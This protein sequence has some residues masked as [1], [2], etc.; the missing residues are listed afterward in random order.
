[1]PLSNDTVQRRIY[2]IADDI[3]QQVV[4]EIRGEPL[5]KFAIQ[6]DESTD[7]ASCAQLLVFAPYIKDG[8]FKE[9]FLFCHCL[10]S[11]TRG[12][13]VFN[14]VSEYFRKRGLSWDNVSACTTDGAPAML[15]NRSGFR[16]RVKAVNPNTKH[17]H[18][19]I[20]R[21]ALAAKTLPPELKA[22]LEDVIHMV[23]C[24]KSSALNTRL[25]RLLCQEF[26]DD[27]EALLFHAE[28]RWLSRGNML[29][30]V[31]SLRNEMVEFFERNNFRG[32]SRD[33][34]NK[35]LDKEWVIRL[36]YLDDIFTR[37][38]LLIKSLQGRFT[39]VVDF[40]D[41]IRAFI[42]KL[43][44]WEGK[45]R[46]GNLDIFENL[47]AAVGSEKL[48]AENIR[49][50]KAHLSC[51]R[52]EFQSYFPDLSEMNV[53]LIRNP[54]IVEVRSLPDEVQEE[55]VEFV[56]DSTAKDALRPYH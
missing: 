6:L 23:N 20:H 17:I 38:N 31:N 47:T 56:N 35:L 54:F 29:S 14:E 52:E 19:M 8:V 12:E 18:C 5:N 10:E 48:D 55:F 34:S 26:D 49:L 42:M 39:T 15:G 27:Q 43:D 21:Y 9:E 2:D 40:I 16:A 50:V 4:A 32:K 30:R 33:F 1:M 46:D 45:A 13:D 11:T 22:T 44:L 36:S 7:V 37:L 41:K 3:E 28:V 53:T 24:I 25:F 51:L